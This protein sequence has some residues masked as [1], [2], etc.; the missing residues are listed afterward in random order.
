M[1][2]IDFFDVGSRRFP[3]RDFLVE[4]ELRFTYEQVSRMTHQ[5]ANALYSAGVGEG[6]KVALYTP[7]SVFGVIAQYGIWRAG[8]AWVPLNVRS[9]EDEI[10]AA[11]DL[12]QCDFIFFHS[13]FATQ[14][15]ALRTRF[16]CLRGAVCID[17]IHTQGPFLLDW[18]AGHSEVA[19]L[20]SMD[21]QTPCAYMLT[22]GT[23]GNPKAA[24]LTNLM[25]ETLINTWLY[26]F[27]YDVSPVN[28]CVAPLTHAAGAAALQLLPLG[29]TNVIMQE[30]EPATV[31]RNIE[32]HRI[33]TMFLPPTLIYVLLGQ[34]DI[35]EHDYSSLRYIHYAASPMS[36]EKLKQAVEIFGP[37]LAQSYGQTEMPMAVSLLTPREHAEALCSPNLQHRLLSAGGVT[38]AASVAIMDESGKLLPLGAIGEI[39]CRGN[40]CTPRYYM[41]PENT[42]KLQANGWHHTGDIGRIDNTGYLYILDRRNDMII[43]GGFNVFPNEIEQILMQEPAIRECSVIGIPDEKWGEMVIAVAEVNPGIDFKPDAILARCKAALGSIKT[44]KRI[45]VWDALP[46]NSNNKVLKR[47]IRDQFWKGRDRKI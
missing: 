35:R 31:L 26:Y 9:T 14:V 23:T 44:P 33:T 20:T 24:V 1:R 19:P 2:M 17:Q 42:A 29:G 10:R 27:P 36:S 34:P 7:N 13:K 32:R 37:V 3:E 39:V 5:I 12:L 40:L 30:F 38:H 41:D 15:E 11:I 45:E 43:T 6:A 28:L 25:F 22:S 8:A 47:V 46:R 16:H 21:P 4:G 18:I